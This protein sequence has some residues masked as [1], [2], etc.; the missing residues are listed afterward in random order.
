MVAIILKIKAHDKVISSGQNYRLTAVKIQQRQ[1]TLRGQAQE[2]WLASAA[3]LVE[4]VQLLIRAF[5]QQSNTI[6]QIHP[7]R[8]H[9]TKK[10]LRGV[11]TW[12]HGCVCTQP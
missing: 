7:A 8:S 9:D 12:H 1:P 11:S 3:L 10:K 2:M 6:V 5:I 4:V